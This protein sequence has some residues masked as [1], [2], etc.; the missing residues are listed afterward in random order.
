MLKDLSYPPSLEYS[1]DSRNLPVVF[2]MSTI[3]YC[4]Q[5]DLKLGFFSSNAIRTLA[6]G[7]AQFIHNGGK[8]RITTYHFLSY[9]DKQLLIDNQTPSLASETKNHVKDLIEVQ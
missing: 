8:I 1:T 7:F 4:K 3:P 2:F 6:Y 9:N 5:I